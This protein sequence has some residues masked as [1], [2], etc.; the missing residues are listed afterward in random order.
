MRIAEKEE[1][2]IRLFKEM[3]N[4]VPYTKVTKEAH[5]N[6]MREMLPYVPAE[7]KSFIYHVRRYIASKE[8]STNDN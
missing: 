2:G 5:I 1:R 7:K 3:L 4:L 6:C 8:E